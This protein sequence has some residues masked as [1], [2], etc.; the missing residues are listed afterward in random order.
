MVRK[1]RPVADRQK[2]LEPVPPE[3]N[4][5]LVGVRMVYEGA[6]GEEFHCTIS[7]HCRTQ[8]FEFPGIDFHPDGDEPHRTIYSS[9]SVQASVA[10]SLADYFEKS[11]FSRHYSI[12]PSLRYNVNETSATIKSQQRGRVPVFL[13]IEESNQLAPV[14]MDR[15][16]CCIWDEVVVRDGKKESALVGG[17][18]VHNRLAYGGR[19]M[20]SSAEQSTA[21]QYDTGWSPCRSED[22]RSDTQA[23]KPELS[24]D[25]RRQVHGDPANEGD[26]ESEHSNS[27]GFHSLP[28]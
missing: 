23:P 7:G 28:E 20:T 22:S 19:G 25:R 15:G 2:S 13:V 16:E 24:G 14:E 26:G 3:A 10:S 6:G 8:I 11:T 21:G 9:S 18:E 1:Y 4:S 5:T 17:R 12:S 27:D